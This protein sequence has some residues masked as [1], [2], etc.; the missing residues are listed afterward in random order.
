MTITKAE[1][2][3]AAN[4]LVSAI[5]EAY[6]I[7]IAALDQAAAEL[8]EDGTIENLEITESGEIGSARGILVYLQGLKAKIYNP[9]YVA[10]GFLPEDTAA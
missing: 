3:S 10:A 7:A 4:D 8:Y 5:D 1:V 9:V 2:V 6:E